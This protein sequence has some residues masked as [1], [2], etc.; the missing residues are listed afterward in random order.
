M[1]FLNGLGN[2][3]G[4]VSHGLDQASV[5]NQRAQQIQAA[6]FALDQEKRSLAGQAA[7]FQALVQRG[8][9]P[10]APVGQQLPP[11]TGPMPPQTGQP[12]MPG[13]ASV[14]NQP[15]Q[16]APS[17]PP[18][19]SMA[20]P[21]QGGMQVPPQQGQAQGAPQGGLPTELTTEGQLGIIQ[22]IAQTI[23]AQNPGIDPATLFEATKQQIAL[24]G[25]LSATQKSDLALTLEAIRSQTS[26][27]NTAARVYATER[28]QDIGA[29]SRENVA[30][31]G[32]RSREA[33]GAGHDAASRANTADRIA[34]ADSRLAKTQAA[35]NARQDKSILGRATTK[36]Q[37]ERLAM[38]RTK[39]S[40][41]KQKLAAALAAGGDT[42]QAQKG[43]DDAYN[44][45]LD[46]QT[47]VMGGK[48]SPPAGKVVDFNALPP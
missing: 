16:M 13:Q 7:A 27:A 47:K 14:P 17:G 35:I 38:L 21:P 4:G 8:G 40:Q 20:G 1:G 36:A 12:P 10:Q 48:T 45:I 37:T 46:F 29:A 11:A 2:F 33:V 6:Q 25:G 28:G 19:A 44:Q 22:K 30:N 5:I 32:A 3:A 9:Q 34:D 42:T 18:Q 43:V 26:Q 24:L 41:A 23:K 39:L 15:S 31:I